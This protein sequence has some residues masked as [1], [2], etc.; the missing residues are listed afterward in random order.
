[1]LSSWSRFRDES[2]LAVLVVIGAVVYGGLV[3]ALFGRRWLSLFRGGA[4]VS[5]SIPPSSNVDQI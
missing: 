2:A 4:P 1:M 5:A 3:I